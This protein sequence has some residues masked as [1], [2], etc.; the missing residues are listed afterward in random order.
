MLRDEGFPVWGSIP[1]MRM[2][3]NNVIGV[4]GAGLNTMEILSS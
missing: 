3:K 1:N 4:Y 2:K